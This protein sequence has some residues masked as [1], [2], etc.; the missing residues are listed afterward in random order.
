MTAI[1]TPLPKFK[2]FVP[3]SNKP[4]V[5]YKLYSYRAGTTTPQATYTDSTGMT[6]NPNPVVMDANGEGDVWLLPGLSY[7]LVLMDTFGVQVWVVDNVQAI[8]DATTLSVVLSGANVVSRYLNNVLSDLVSIKFF[9]GADPTGVNDSSLALTYA[10]NYLG[11][12]G[13]IKVP[14]GI[15][16]FNLTMDRSWSG[17]TVDGPGTSESQLAPTT[18]YFKPYDFTRPVFTIGDG[19]A[20][21][22]AGSMLRNICFYGA[23]TGYYGVAYAGGAIRNF[24]ENIQILNFTKRGL[25][26][27]C[28]AGVSPCT[29]NKI[30][31]LTIA[32]SVVGADGAYFEDAGNNNL[33]YTT[34]NVLSNFDITSNNGYQIHC[35]SA[36][37]NF[38]SN[39]YIQQ[40]YSGLGVLF[41]KSYSRAPQFFVSSVIMD[42]ASGV[43]AVNSIIDMGQDYE[44]VAS[45]GASPWLGH[46]NF[47]GPIFNVSQKTTGSITAGSNSLIVAS[48]T[49]LNSGRAVVVF[50]ADTS[51]R[52]LILP[53][54]S[55]NGT[56]V[57]LT[58]NAVTTV[59]NAVVWIG[60]LLSDMPFPQVGKN[61]MSAPGMAMYPSKLSRMLP[62]GLK[63]GLYK[64]GGL[65]QGILSSFDVIWDLGGLQK[66]YAQDDGLS[67]TISSATQGAAVQAWGTASFATN[68]MTV[69]AVGNGSGSFAVGQVIEAAGVAAGTTISSLGT[70]TGGTGTYNLST[71]PGTIAAENVVTR[72]AGAG[73]SVLVTTTATNSAQ[74][75]DM[76]EINGANERGINGSFIVLTRLNTTQF[77]YTSSVSQSLTSISGSTTLKVN[78]I[79]KWQYG[80]F[81]VG[82][83]IKIRDQFGNWTNAI[84][85]NT[86]NTNLTI[87]TPDTATGGMVFQA[88]SSPTSSAKYVFTAGGVSSIILNGYGCVGLG[89]N[90]N[91]TS[92]SLLIGK[93]SPGTPTANANGGILWCDSTGALKYT[94]PAGTVSTVAP[95]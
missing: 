81:H 43:N 27:Y 59:T 32:T 88:G 11:G 94:S 51:G 73:T 45:Y 53:V 83:T 90:N 63:G 54:Q 67:S 31:N 41:E 89:Y 91:D 25:Q 13:T 68:V 4:G 3:G 86:N 26:F 19:T 35:N 49:G 22:T 21:A 12:K 80:N 76:I 38:L 95:A 87:Q 9:S 17:I 75:E 48:A 15:W 5:G 20:A 16:A 55:V 74:K 34:A 69:T 44:L 52:M 64:S 93:R 85:Q 71:S 18:N 56:T 40:A 66:Y 60:D 24:G 70:G 39:G 29:Y 28:N 2:A 42:N 82:G 92:L 37:G 47:T 61:F 7:K 77:V 36:N 6:P 14:N 78:K 72:T 58:A 65:G 30:N 23:N 46:I 79:S 84:Y 33:A 62:V 50:G 1:L 57:T 10:K 8:Q